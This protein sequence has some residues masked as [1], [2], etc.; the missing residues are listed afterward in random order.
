MMCYCGVAT[1][2]PSVIVGVLLVV[3]VLLGIVVNCYC[4]GGG[5]CEG[6]TIGVDGCDN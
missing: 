3:S 2:C 4:G 1:V 5:N 6:V